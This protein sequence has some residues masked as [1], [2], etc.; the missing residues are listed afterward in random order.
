MPLMSICLVLVFAGFIHRREA[1]E[2]LVESKVTVPFLMKSWRSDDPIGS[3][4]TFR[5]M[6]RVFRWCLQEV[7]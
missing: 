7:N 1:I 3:T 5:K 4:I 6:F 2:K